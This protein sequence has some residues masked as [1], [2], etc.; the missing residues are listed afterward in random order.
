MKNK[1]QKRG[2]TPP[3]V[4][5][6]ERISWECQR[7]FYSCLR[8]PVLA[9]IPLQI[10]G[11]LFV[12]PKGA[13]QI[14]L[15]L[16]PL[17][18]LIT[19]SSVFFVC[20]IQGNQKILLLTMILL[21]VGTMLQSLFKAEYLAKN[22]EGSSGR[23]LTLGLQ[24]QYVAALVLAILTG[25]IYWNIRECSS[26]KMAEFLTILSFFLSVFTLVFAKSVGNVRN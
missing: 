26:L 23:S 9:V 21:T 14:Y 10:A 17:L 16:L 18:I 2:L 13:G 22:P 7:A 8:S 19:L 6:G 11:L 24:L 4:P 3:R 20:L 1:H 12:S 25:F 15:D 5:T